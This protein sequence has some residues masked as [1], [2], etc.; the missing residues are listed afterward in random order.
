MAHVVHVMTRMSDQMT[1]G[2]RISDLVHIIPYSCRA[3]KRRFRYLNRSAAN[4]PSACRIAFIFLNDA[5]IL[6]YGSNLDRMEFSERTHTSAHGES[7]SLKLFNLLSG[8]R[9]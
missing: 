3:A 2:S 7:C 8:Y 6:P 1:S 4:I 5:M 9:P